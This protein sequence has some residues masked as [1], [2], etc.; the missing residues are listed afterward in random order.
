MLNLLGHVRQLKCLLWI[1]VVN[2]WLQVYNIESLYLRGWRITNVFALLLILENLSL[3]LYQILVVRTTI[4]RAAIHVSLGDLVLL[5]KSRLNF[6]EH[7]HFL[8]QYFFS[9]AKRSWFR[10]HLILWSRCRLSTII[11]IIVVFFQ[12]ILSFFHE[13]CH[14]I[15]FYQNLL[16]LDTS[17]S[18]WV[19]ITSLLFSRI[20]NLRLE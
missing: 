5:R 1:I 18:E 9:F 15:L 16:L 10:W 12:F 6:F 17:S 3:L 11:I 13:L 2:G 4:H 19:Q 14:S 7:L 8:C 20:S